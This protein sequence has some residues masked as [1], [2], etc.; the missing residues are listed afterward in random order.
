MIVATT[1][2]NP[3]FRNSPAFSSVPAVAKRLVTPTPAQL[4]E[5]FGM[6]SA[7][8]RDTGRM[9]YESTAVKTVIAF[10]V[11]VAGAAIG[12]NVPG[13]WIVGALVGLVLAMVNIFKKKVSPPLILA[14]AAFEGLFVGGISR[15]YET[16]YAGI[17]PQAVFGTLAVIGVTLALFA[18]GKVRAS[19]RATKIFLIAMLGYL[20]YSIVNVILVV[21]GVTSSM[22]GLDSQVKIFGLPLGIVIGVLLVIMAAYSLVL[23]FDSIQQ[24]VRRGAPGVYAW[25]GAFG[26]MVT[27]VWLYL[28]I[29]RIIGLARSN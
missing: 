20:A 13:V 18:S 17:V 25:Q 16:L 12:W 5:Q 3:A 21:T 11:L 26:I 27:V 10:A 14:Y 23:D 22:Y 8:P 28:S 1:N 15:A 29:L 2:S 19:A 7:T 9:T 6:P 24:G 4:D